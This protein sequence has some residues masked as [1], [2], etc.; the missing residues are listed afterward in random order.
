M[1]LIIGFAV[2]PIYVFR[3]HPNMQIFVHLFALLA[4]RMYSFYIYEYENDKN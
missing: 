1:N 3:R 4:L 2:G